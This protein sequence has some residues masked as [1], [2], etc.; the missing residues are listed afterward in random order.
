MRRNDFLCSPIA[1][2]SCF[3]WRAF[4]NGGEDDRHQSA[5]CL[6]FLG[7]LTIPTINFINTQSCDCL[8]SVLRASY[9]VLC[10]QPYAFTISLLPSARLR[11]CLQLTAAESGK[12]RDQRKSA[13]PSFRGHRTGLLSLSALTYPPFV[14]LRPALEADHA[15]PAHVGRL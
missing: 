11:H 2:Q 9:F 15:L 10:M 6:S 14:L 7:Q 12:C 5:A 13:G 4:P 8:S 1:S 3:F